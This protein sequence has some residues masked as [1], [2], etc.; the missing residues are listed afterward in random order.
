MLKEIF[1]KRFHS[2]HSQ[3]YSQSVVQQNID[4]AVNVLLNS[5]YMLAKFDS[6]IIIRD[7]INNI[8]NL[9][10]YFTT[11]DRYIIDT[12]IVNKSGEGASE[13]KD[14]LLRDITD[15][16]KGDYYSLEKI[17]QRQ[18]RLFR[19]GLFNS[20]I[21]SANEKDTSGNKVPLKLNGSIGLMNELIPGNY[22]K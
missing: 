13:V 5:G 16:R 17:R 12:V 8:A 1:K 3:F 20:V 6:T 4:Q 18:I 9:D 10:I 7:T 11:G 14:N 15:I 22:L 21:L 2:I 19:T